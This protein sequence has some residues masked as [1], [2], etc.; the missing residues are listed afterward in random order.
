M[1]ELY[2]RK[3]QDDVG[4][5]FVSSLRT[6][7]IKWLEEVG[8]EDYCKYGIGLSP[9]LYQALI[10]DMIGNIKTFLGIEFFCNNELLDDCYGL[11]Y[12]NNP[13]IETLNDW[14]IDLSLTER[15]WLY[16]HWKTEYPD[17]V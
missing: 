8:K 17:Y 10:D 12:N 16:Y 4:I 14:W 6:S 9:I 5:S 1:E 7:V 15:N 3:L 11:Y 2:V 13:D